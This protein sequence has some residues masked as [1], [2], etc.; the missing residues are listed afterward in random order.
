LLKAILS[1]HGSDLSHLIGFRHVAL[2]L[3][4]NQMFYSLF[5]KDMVTSPTPFLEAKPGQQV[6]QIVKADVCVR[7]PAQN[8]LKNF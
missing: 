3:K 7:T 5:Y 8:S 1:D 4:I 2:S 6:S